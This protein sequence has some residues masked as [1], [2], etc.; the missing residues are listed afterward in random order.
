[1][2]TR[3]RYR[4][5][6]TAH[7]TAPVSLCNNVVESVWGHGCNGRF[8]AR[9]TECYPWMT[10]SESRFSDVFYSPATAC[11]EGWL[12]HST[13]TTSSRTTEGWV[14]GETAITYCP[15]SYIGTFDRCILETG[16]VYTNTLCQDGRTSEEVVTFT[17][18]G[19]IRPSADYLRL[20]Y[21][22][23]DLIATVT[24]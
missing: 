11:P 24:G 8:P 23:S 14:P 1:M 7:T 10:A 18:S 21:Q 20:R 13:R 12:T 17:R 5:W 2:T 3:T 4:P 16:D 22:Q 9:L 6:N 19:L 15:Q